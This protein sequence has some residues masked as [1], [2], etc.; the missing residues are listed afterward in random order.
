MPDMADMRDTLSPKPDMRDTLGT[1]PRTPTAR[2]GSTQRPTQSP[3]A[4]P[5]TP[6]PCIPR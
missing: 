3:R 2:R 4:E 6:A 1:T 5:S